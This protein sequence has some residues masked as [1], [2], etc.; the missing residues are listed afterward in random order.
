M[1]GW[2]EVVPSH[3]LPAC[4]ALLSPSLKCR[5]DQT[6]LL[7]SK[8]QWLLAVFATELKSKLL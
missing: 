4:S 6:A 5:S 1:A 3:Y 7:L 2:L 8:P